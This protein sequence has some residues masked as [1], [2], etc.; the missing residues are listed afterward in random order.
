MAITS[1]AG[2]GSD[3]PSRRRGSTVA[4]GGSLAS[5]LSGLGGSGD[6]RSGGVVRYPDGSYHD[7][8]G[9]VVGSASGGAGGSGGSGGGSALPATTNQANYNPQMN[10]ALSRILGRAS[11]DAGAGTAIDLAGGKIREASIG[12]QREAAVGRQM[13]GGAGT[14]ANSYDQAKISDATQRAI[15]GASSDIS[16]AAESRKDTLL[17]SAANVAGSMAQLAQGDRSLALQQW[18][19]QEANRRADENARIAQQQAQLQA[20]IQLSQVA[21]TL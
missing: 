20:L 21:T 3:D 16:N 18:Q 19:Q 5:V 4:A 6:T 1:S 17:G 11:G 12:A 15:A 13:R 8:T 10:D 9:R 14:S 7:S 2:I